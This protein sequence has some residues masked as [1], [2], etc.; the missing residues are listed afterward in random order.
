VLNEAGDAILVDLG[1]VVRR[2][3]PST[4]STSESTVVYVPR[5]FQPRPNHSPS[6]NKY[7]AEELCDWW[8]LAMT[9]AEKVYGKEIGGAAPPLTKQVLQDLLQEE[10]SSLIARLTSI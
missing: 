9:V 8:M 2:S 4:P 10:F 5:D 1:S 3:S 7:V 6:N